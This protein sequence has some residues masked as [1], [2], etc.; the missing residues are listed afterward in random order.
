MGAIITGT[1]EEA[2]KTLGRYP[3]ENTT[4]S[5]VS[6]SVAFARKGI[7]KLLNFL[8]LRP[9]IEISVKGTEGFWGATRLVGHIS[10]ELLFFAE[11]KILIILGLRESL[12]PVDRLSDHLDLIRRIAL[13][14]QA[15]QNR[16]HT[17]SRHTVNGYVFFFQSFYDP[18][19]GKPAR[20]DPPA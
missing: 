2:R 13:G 17:C 6:I 8:V 19:F 15:P 5:P 14:Q 10:A 9:L 18:D 3:E 16:P 12:G 20:N 4:S 11:K 7:L 1:A